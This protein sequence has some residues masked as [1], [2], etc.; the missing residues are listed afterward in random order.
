M[1]CFGSFWHRSPEIQRHR[2]Q[3]IEKP[4]IR[5]CRRTRSYGFGQDPKRIIGHSKGFSGRIWPQKM[6]LMALVPRGK[7]VLM[8][9]HRCSLSRSGLKLDRFWYIGRKRIWEV[10][11]ISQNLAGPC[12]GNAKPI[13]PAAMRGLYVVYIAACLV[14]R[15]WRFALP[16]VLSYINGGYRAIAVLG[17]VSPLFVSL[18]GPI[19]GSFLDKI[20]RPYGLGLM[21][22]L[23]D[24]A[25]IA[26]GVVVILS[27]TT[28]GASLA[29]GPLFS[30]LLALSGVER[31]TAVLS[32]LAI[33]RDWVTQL[34]GRD[35]DIALATSN[36]ILRRGDLVCEAIGAMAFGWLYSCSGL[37]AAV[38]V[39]VIL[40]AVAVPLQ[41]Y[42]ILFIAKRAPDAMVHG[43]G[44]ATTAPIKPPTWKQLL[45][46]RKDMVSKT[47]KAKRPIRHHMIKHYASFLDGW[48]T[49]FRQPILFSSLT[50]VLLFLNVAL[51]PGGLI[52]AFLTSK[53]LDGKGMAMFRGG[54][55]CKFEILF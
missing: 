33:E 18:L 1:V 49:Y 20:Y 54:C 19:V 26:S 8:A 3:M 47:S 44:E 13:H 50:F 43:R 6:V 12:M 30:A 7:S 40:A 17:F 42:F 9:S 29:N 24:I 36:A 39:T 31:L 32:E 38:A 22:T 35:N 21:L 15:T 2:R 27:A 10:C 45:N 51:S 16:L 37:V 48:K 28:P 4:S 25:I 14:E 34:S 11:K 55:A 5:L 53:G 46:V 23:Q 52:T 41:L